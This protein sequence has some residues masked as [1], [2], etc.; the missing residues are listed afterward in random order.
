MRKTSIPIMV[1]AIFSITILLMHDNIRLASAIEIFDVAQTNTPDSM[2]YIAGLDK[3]I[4]VNGGDVRVV[5]PTT[6]AVVASYQLNTGIDDVSCSN[7]ICYGVDN[8]GA[9]NE[10]FI[11]GFNPMTGATVSNA[12]FNFGSG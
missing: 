5:E 6:Y 2:A 3:Y 7:S 12:T 8:G 10:Q 4:S 1:L 11:F 9:D